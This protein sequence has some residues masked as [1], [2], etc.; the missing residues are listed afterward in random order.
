MSL[1]AFAYRRSDLEVPGDQS[2]FLV[3]RDAGLLLTACSYAGS[4]W[5]HLDTGDR[6]LLRLSAG[7]ID[8]SRHTEMDGDALERALARD[9]ATTI[10]VEAPPAAA[11][12]SRW[13]R[14]LPQ[15]S[16]GHADRMAAIDSR[17]AEVAPGLVVTGAFRHGVGIPACIRSGIEAA[18]AV[19]GHVA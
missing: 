17:L 2:G 18:A 16:P 13:P 5:A 7:R 11:R 14:S 3:P 1:A 15:F 9:L 6:V 19:A 12:I 8:D 10:G 4:K